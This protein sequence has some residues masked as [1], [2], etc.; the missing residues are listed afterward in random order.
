VTKTITAICL[1][2]AVFNPAAA[3]TM[4]S[5]VSALV[6]QVNLDSLTTTVAQLTGERPIMLEGRPYT[7]TSRAAYHLDND[8]AADFIERK[9][10]GYGLQTQQHEFSSTG[11]NV[12]AFQTGL[13]R[14]EQIY[15]VCAHFDAVPLNRR[16]PSGP[17]VPGADDNASGTAAVLEAARL[18]STIDLPYS[19]LYALWDEE[20]TGLVGS[21]VYAGEAADANLDIKLVL[22]ADM[23]A[24]DSDGDGKLTIQATNQWIVDAI[25][26]AR[27]A[28][29]LNLEPI[30]SSSFAR[31]DHVP[32]RDE[33][34]PSAMMIEYWDEPIGADF[35]PYY[36]SALDML[37]NLNTAYHRE[38]T[39]LLVATVGS[40]AGDWSSVTSVD[41]IAET[42]S[43]MTV[44]S[45]P[46]PF[47]GSATFEVPPAVSGAAM[48]EVFD[49]LGRIVYRT[50]EFES[51]GNGQR[52]VVD[53]SHL[54]SGTYLY[55]LRVG[56]ERWSG[57]MTRR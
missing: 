23:I 52:I 10:A 12:L 38:M 24:W 19:V 48:L 14:P 54:P 57:T 50:S 21:R 20:E 29:Q 33:G 56:S 8:R 36:H 51:G 47:S 22:N 9:L 1:A 32:F 11:R 13:V 43:R 27:E 46:N 4:S 45:F 28:L 31:S 3:Q 6:G 55:H 41:P 26:R 2:T 40:L 5:E 18:L 16:D 17:G 34:Y 15:V 53:G 30:W 7:L 44:A 35:N 37:A 49:V 42:R 25:V 39:R